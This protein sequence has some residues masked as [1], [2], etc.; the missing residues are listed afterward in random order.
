MS[1]TPT[2]LIIPEKSKQCSLS[3]GYS[4]EPQA[5]NPSRDIYCFESFD[6]V[7]HFM[8]KFSRVMQT[9]TKADLALDWKFSAPT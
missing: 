1:V 3:A 8:N 9:Y 5:K 6:F 7:L 4:Y 2:A